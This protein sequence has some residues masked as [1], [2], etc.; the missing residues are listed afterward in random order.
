M[1]FT[2]LQG[3]KQIVQDSDYYK[4]IKQKQYKDLFL[5]KTNFIIHSILQGN[6]HLYKSNKLEAVPLHNDILLHQVGRNYQSVFNVLFE[7][8][9]VETNGSYTVGEH[10]KRY[11]LTKKA[12]E[13]NIVKVGILHKNT[14][15]KYETFRRNLLSSLL[16][17]KDIAK[18]FYSITDLYYNPPADIDAFLDELIGTEIT[19]QRMHYLDWHKQLVQFNSF[20]TKEDY[21]NSNF[22]IMRCKKT[23]RIYNTYTHIPKA[24]R[25]RL[26]S[27]D[28][29]E[30][31]EVDGKNSQ[32]YILANMFYIASNNID[33]AYIKNIRYTNKIINNNIKRLNI[34]SSICMQDVPEATT[35]LKNLY[36][37]NY[38]FYNN[39]IQVKNDLGLQ[40]KI[41]TNNRSEIKPYVLKAIYGYYNNELST[42]E[43][44][45]K[46]MYPNLLK[47]IRSTKKKLGTLQIDKA[48]ASNKLFAHII[49]NIES[50]IYVKRFF[51]KLQVG[52]LAFSVHD[53]IVCKKQDEAYVRD[54]L[55]DSI[56]EE[57]KDIK[58]NPITINKIIK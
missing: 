29:E 31:V 46:V 32:L 19:E 25:S 28:K 33:D 58:L 17:D 55:V 1:Y 11:K 13:Y 51:S 20:R 14:I 26:T 40:E 30:L 48:S 2:T 8:G 34:Y 56:I 45:L 35:L 10:S 24:F 49:Q 53:S 42:E 39:F 38:D 50:N 21:A 4:R 9:I 16:K 36:N 6:Q 52:K 18:Q 3:T 7:A 57:F 22:Y 47:F 12:L 41:P 44:V 23:G 54:L 15:K 5:D 43:E 27:R 37:T